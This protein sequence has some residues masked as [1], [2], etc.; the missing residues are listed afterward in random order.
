MSHNRAKFSLV[1][2]RLNG[3][4]LKLTDFA[5]DANPMQGQGDKGGEKEKEEPKYEAPEGL[6]FE[7]CMSA[8]EISLHKNS[9]TTYL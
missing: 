1:H 2:I 5:I 8:L 9:Q 7:L 6:V 4:V 3:F